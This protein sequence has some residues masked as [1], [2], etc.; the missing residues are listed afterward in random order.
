MTSHQL[1]FEV[2]AKRYRDPHAWTVSQHRSIEA[3]MTSL[4]ST[5]GGRK[6]RLAGLESA[7][8]WCARDNHSYSLYRAAELSAEGYFDDIA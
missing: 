3:A 5:I 7:Y 1:P 2:H 8:I 4:R 6:H